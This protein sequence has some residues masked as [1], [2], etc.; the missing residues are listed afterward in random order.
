[1][2]AVTGDLAINL[3]AAL[4]RVLVLF[5]HDDAGTLPH[6][7]AVAF[8]VERARRVLR[9]VI[10]RAHRFHRAKS[11]DAEGHDR[12]FRAA[13][14]HD[15][16]IAHLDGAPR[17]ADGVVRGGTG[18]TGGEIRLPPQIVIHRKQAGTHVEDEHRNHERREP[19]GAAL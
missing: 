19:S 11:A 13:G 12:R 10:A 4:L 14:E 3:R 18:G 16:R 6:D 7:E 5:K 8:L 15:G 17:L 2:V 1:M 9:I